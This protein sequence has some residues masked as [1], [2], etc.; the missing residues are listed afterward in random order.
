MFSVR[1]NTFMAAFV[2]GLAVVA[3]LSMF[4]T[5]GVQV[6]SLALAPQIDTFALMS[7]ARNLPIQ[8]VNSTF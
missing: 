3:A 6:Q 7:D 1:Q 8:V 4:A 2:G 5:A